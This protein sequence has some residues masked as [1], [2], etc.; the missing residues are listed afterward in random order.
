MLTKIRAAYFYCVLTK[1]AVTLLSL[2]VFVILLATQLPNLKIDASSDA[3]T[4]EYDKDLDYFREMSKRYQSGDFLVITY[5]P[6]GDLFDDKTLQH[7]KALRD[8]LLAI[9][10]ISGANSVLD[11]P[12]LYSPP[13]S[14]T[15]VSKGVKTLLD[16]GVDYTLAKQEFL[17]SPIYK[18]MLLGP[19]GKTT[20]ILLTLAT[21]N[22]YI[23]LVRE[24]DALRKKR[25]AEG[26]TED[27]RQQLEA[28]S[29]TFLEYRTQ[30]TI[31]SRQRV[32]K[33]RAIVARYK[34]QATIFV[35][36]V[37]MI[38]AD[39]VDF[40]ASDIVV[41]GSSIVIFIILILSFIFRRWQLVCL[42]LVTCV[43]SLFAMLGFLAA[44]DWRLTVIS[45]NFVALLLIICLMITIHLIVRYRELCVD[46]PDLG[47][48]E[49]LRSTL[50][51]MFKPCLY[52]VLTTIVAFISLVVSGIRPVI[53]FGWMMTIGLCVA[54]LFAFIVIPTGLLLLPKVHL[55][56]NKDKSAAFTLIFS[57]FTEK[58]GGLILV[59]STL[60]VVLS[61]IGV[62]R[63]EV[64]NRFIDYFHSSTEIH[65]GMLVID[66]QLGGTITL[67][68]ILD[69]KKVVNTEVTKPVSIES[70]EFSDDSIVNNDPFA[71]DPFTPAIPAPSSL[72]VS[73]SEEFSVES[74]DDPFAEEDPFTA[75]DP[76]SAT[77]TASNANAS[78]HNLTNNYWFTQVGME[79]IE[80]VHDYL[81]G[82]SEVGK[83]Q[84]LAMSYKVARD[85]NGKSLNNFELALMGQALPEEIKSFLIDPYLAKDREQ[86]RIAMRVKETD[87]NL[88]RDQLLEKVRT[89]LTNTLGFDADQVHLTGV[90]VLYNNMLQS[91]FSSQILTIGAVFIGILL[92]FL[93]LFRSI[94][95]SLIALIPNVLAALV[96]LG[97]MGLA[98]IPLDMM[99]I[100]I[101]A[102]AVGIGVDD[103]VHYIYRYREEFA[104]SK[105][106]V[107]AMHTAHSSIGKAMYYTS[108][109]VIVGFSI[110]ALSKFIPSI[111]FG[112]LTGLAMFAA[113]TAS[114]TLLPKLILLFQPL[115]PESAD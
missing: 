107:A 28:V 63:L 89:D 60:A 99:T 7:L 87:I 23:E 66:Q 13:V 6:N 92:M 55:T 104:Q 26:L 64:E 85:L 93:V 71:G 49:N 32:E 69:R 76:F 103:A 73:A 31:E 41:F 21:D 38:T 30:S 79:R 75:K 33:V 40:I 48:R 100:T 106:Y 25:D 94:L 57:R 17:A 51:F 114:L 108:V 54:F 9:E 58:R 4:L 74:S 67:D 86:T 109:T 14:L 82:L 37:S 24:R 18:D 65:Q 62:S 39:M 98:G 12:L 42:P 96:V 22:Y 10:G 52:T 102:I 97:G 59:L 56:E 45:S 16:E 53:D 47:I 46:R 88:R 112:L 113:I 105:N 3:L 101:A 70:D 5:T 78:R 115:G 95:L 110:L 19:D 77:E 34:S 27:E 80:T 11:V 8:E 84:S 83:V 50:Q 2:I 68:I 81:D 29:K 15:E 61:V 1:P 72:V 43:L 20:A 36:G 91:L 90:L 44:V 35:G 111:Y